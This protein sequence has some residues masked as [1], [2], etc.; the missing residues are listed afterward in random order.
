M[1]LDAVGRPALVFDNL[2]PA[3]PTVSL[4]IDDMGAHVKFDRMGG[5]TS[6]V[7]LNNAG[8]SGIVL[9]DAVGERRFSA[10]VSADG[11]TTVHPVAPHD[12]P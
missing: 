7:F 12:A 5:A 4:E 3:L 2:S 8:G 11:D 1:K 9:C 6:Y 10:T